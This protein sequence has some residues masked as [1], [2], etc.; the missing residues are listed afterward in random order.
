[1]SAGTKTQRCQLANAYLSQTPMYLSQTGPPDICVYRRVQATNIHKGVVC[2]CKIQAP[3]ATRDGPPLTAGR[4][5]PSGRCPSNVQ[6]AHQTITQGGGGGVSQPHEQSEEFP[7]K[8]PAFRT[9][10]P[11]GQGTGG[12]SPPGQ[13]DAAPQASTQ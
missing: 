4:S 7:K 11:A 2:V 13:K 6:N 8:P 12:A 1:V 3:S 9:A 10:R 5:Q